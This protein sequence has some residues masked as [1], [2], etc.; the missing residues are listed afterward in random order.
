V[1]RENVHA[2]LCIF[3]QIILKV[4]QLLLLHNVEWVVLLPTLLL[5][6][7][8]H[9]LHIAGHPLHGCQGKGRHG[10]NSRGER[11]QHCAARLRNPKLQQGS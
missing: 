8:Q 4:P 2:P 9:A 7:L 1:L 3:Q 5:L 11:A 6:L 10:S